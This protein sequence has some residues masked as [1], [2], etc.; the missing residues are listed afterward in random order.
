MTD[1]YLS[2]VYMCA[3]VYTHMCAHP[4]MST[5]RD[6]KLLDS[7]ELEVLAVGGCLTWALKTELLLTSELPIHPPSGVFKCRLLQ[8]PT[9]Q[10]TDRLSNGPRRGLAHLCN[11][12]LLEQVKRPAI[13]RLRKETASWWKM[14]QNHIAQRDLILKATLGTK[15]AREWSILQNKWKIVLFLFHLTWPRVSLEFLTHVTTWGENQSGHRGNANTN[16]R[17]WYG[18]WYLTCYALMGP[19][20]LR[21]SFHA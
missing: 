15:Y 7:L 14:R 9:H 21:H 20:L 1:F 13:S 18:P 12:L 8:C 4:C 2:Y 3:T 19:V 16:E 5:R 6:Q 10:G 11:F 17:L